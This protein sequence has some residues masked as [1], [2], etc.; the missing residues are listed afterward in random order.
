MNVNVLFGL[1]AAVCLV[2][3]GVIFADL[4]GRLM[5]GAGYLY[6]PTED[7]C[8]GHIL[9]RCILFFCALVVA[10]VFCKLIQE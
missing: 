7:G 2:I 9:G 4:V 1:L 3:A 5:F 8:L 6:C 10:Y